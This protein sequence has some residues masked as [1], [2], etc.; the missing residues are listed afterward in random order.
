MRKHITAAALGLS[1]LATPAL[2][3]DIVIM[4]FGRQQGGC[5]AWVS[6]T[7][8]YADVAYGSWLLGFLSGFNFA[9]NNDITGGAPASSVVDQMKLYCRN[10]PMEF[11]CEAGTALIGEMLPRA[12]SASSGAP[13][14]ILPTRRR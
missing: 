7:D 1:L 9:V 2:A 13:D 11:P 14:T 5:G 3:G 12:P 4:G 8:R 6:S 10:H